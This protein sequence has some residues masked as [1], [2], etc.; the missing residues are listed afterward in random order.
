MEAFGI[1]RNDGT[2]NMFIFRDN[3]AVKKPHG[4]RG[5]SGLKVGSQLQLVPSMMW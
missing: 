4:L 2:E 1:W 5:A 3:D